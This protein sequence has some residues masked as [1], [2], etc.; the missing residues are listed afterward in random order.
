MLKAALLP[1]IYAELR[2]RF[3][4]SA[5]DELIDHYLRIDRPGGTFNQDAVGGVIADYRDT[6]RFAKLSDADTIDSTER[7]GADDSPGDVAVGSL[8]QWVSQGV[9]QFEQ[10]RRVRGLSDDGE[11]AFVEGGMTGVAVEE[12]IVVEEP[13]AK[14]DPAV[15]TPPRNPFFENA[16]TPA[17]DTAEAKYTLDE[18][19]VLIRWPSKMSPDSYRD[20]EYFLNGL[21][22][23][24]KRTAGIED[25]PAKGG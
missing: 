3:D 24:A 12:L 18:G 25:K 23:R 5:A 21:L 15:K 17:K 6:L 19:P 2:A 9:N 20:F 10:P 4:D 13:K 11:W 16:D 8:V 14:P 1:P 22:N 7:S